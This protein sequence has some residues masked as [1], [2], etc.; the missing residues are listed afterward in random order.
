MLEPLVGQIGPET[1]RQGESWSHRWN[2]PDLKTRKQSEFWSHWWDRP[3]LKQG[4]KVSVGATGGT[5]RI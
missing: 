5:D 1:G 4:D 3:D 2:R